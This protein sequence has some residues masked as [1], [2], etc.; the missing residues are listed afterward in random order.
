MAEY[1]YIPIGNIQQNDTVIDSILVRLTTYVEG[2]YPS[3]LD[4]EGNGIHN[5]LE[6]EDATLTEAQRL[7]IAELQGQ[8]FPDAAS[9][10]AWKDW[11]RENPEQ[12]PNT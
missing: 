9:Y 8:W 12:A 3:V 5:I 4:S 7:R 6:L 11:I 1:A 10:I 2:K